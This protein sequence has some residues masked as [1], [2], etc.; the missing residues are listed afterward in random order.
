MNP[1]MSVGEL[2]DELALIAG[3][4]SEDEYRDLLL[5]LPLT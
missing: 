1:G 3:A 4:S 5:Y 2:V